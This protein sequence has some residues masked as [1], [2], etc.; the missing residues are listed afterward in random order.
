MRG[1]D[2]EKLSCSRAHFARRLVSL[3]FALSR[4]ALHESLGTAS[5]ARQESKHSGVARQ[6]LMPNPLNYVVPAID[7]NMLYLLD[8]VETKNIL[9]LSTKWKTFSAIQLYLQ[10]E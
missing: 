2:N 7:M 5:P 4:A 6:M 1:T 8:G 9:V 3:G 10:C